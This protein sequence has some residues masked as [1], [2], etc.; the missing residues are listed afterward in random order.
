MIYQCACILVIVLCSR[1]ARHVSS[2]CFTSA[3][4]NSVLVA[5]R[6]G[7]LYRFDMPSATATSNSSKVQSLTVSASD[8]A[9][10][11]GAAPNS[12]VSA[13]PA[14]AP[15]K[16]ARTDDSNDEE[17]GDGAY[18]LGHVS[19]LLDCVRVVLSLYAHYVIILLLRV[20]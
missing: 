5:D 6:S 1:V 14:V 20:N 19:M 17:T 7:A 9:T 11:T 8:A 4:D 16:R 18:L 15:A 13:A 2:L 3:H 10:G 12:N